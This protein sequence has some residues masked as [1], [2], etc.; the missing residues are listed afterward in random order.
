MSENTLAKPGEFDA[1]EKA[2]PD[3][4]IFPLLERDPCAPPTIRFWVDLRRRRAL[5]EIE[6]IDALKDELRQCTEAEFIAIEM[7]RRRKGEVAEVAETRASYSGEA[8]AKPLADDLMGKLR[9]RLG[10]ADYHAHEA[11]DLMQQIVTAGGELPHSIGDELAAA[12]A[13]LHRIALEL[14]PY[15]AQY[16]AEGELPLAD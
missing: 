7:E 10:E 8:V 13:T 5:G 9:A 6:D 14:S 15:R 11:I 12:A 2:R 4:L 3:E 1:L 16:L